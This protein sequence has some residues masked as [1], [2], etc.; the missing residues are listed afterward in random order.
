MIRFASPSGISQGT[1]VVYGNR[2][3]LGLGQ[4][5]IAA[6][7]TVFLAVCA[8]ISFPIPM[9]PIP[10]T[11]Q[12]F[13]VLLIGIVLGPL[14]GAVSIVLYLGEGA[15]GLPVFSPHGLGGFAQL[16]GPS[17]GY[18]LSYPVAAGLVGWFYSFANRSLQ[19]FPSAVLAAFLA[20]AVILLS[21]SAWLTTSLHLSP[22]KALELGVLPFLAGEMCKVLLFATMTSSLQRARTRS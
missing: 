6:S 3:L 19:P 11:M 17:A 13:A 16:T 4:L 15:L 22:V 5:A 8:H 2:S 14:A 7:A 9:T 21:G 1:S 10:V 12:T 18:L 20:D